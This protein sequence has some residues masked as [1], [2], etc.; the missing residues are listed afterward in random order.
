MLFPTIIVENFFEKPKELINFSKKLEYEKDKVNSWPGVRSKSF[1]IINEK[2]YFFVI[3]KVLSY[4]YDYNLLTLN[5]EE[6]LFDNTYVGFHKIKEKDIKGFKDL[7]HRDYETH[8][9]GLIYLNNENNIKTGTKLYS[10]CEVVKN[11]FISPKEK[12][13]IANKFNTM[14]A[15]DGNNLHGP[16]GFLK[17][18]KERLNIV[19]FI[20]KIITKKFP[21]E[22]ANLIKGF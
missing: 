22:R 2:L 21:T 10:D 5:N 15:Y 4:F 7:K 12:L 14:I 13:I 1:H 17:N 18:N 3:K 20:N 11:S 9:A 16:S 8:L 19:F 6:M